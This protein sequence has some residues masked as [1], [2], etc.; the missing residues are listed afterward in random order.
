MT[1]R[2]RLFIIANTT[3]YLNIKTY[4]KTHSPADNFVVLT[5]RRFKGYSDFYDRIKH[6]PDFE[7]LKIIFVDQKKK[8]P[9]HYLDIFSIMGNI[10]GVKQKHPEFDEVLFSN[11]N[12]WV[13]HYLLNQYKLIKPILISDGTGIFTIADLRKTSIA[14]PFA[15]SKFFI[16]KVLGLK[17]LESLH[18]YSQVPVNVPDHDSVEIFG[19]SASNSTT[20]DEEKVYFVGSPLVELGY[21][22]KQ[23]HIDFL[24]R[25]KNQFENSNFIYFSHRRE[26]EEN[27]ED[28]KF[29]GKI[30]RDS[31]PFE[32]RM[33]KEE[34]LPGIVIS[35]ISSILIN[36]PQV[37]PQVKFYYRSLDKNDL[38]IN[39]NF[40]ERYIELT[41]NFK[42]MEG[43]NFKELK[44]Q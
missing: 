22:E 4:I 18:F 32:E 3:H 28:Y 11:Y 14:I 17:P 43:D 21:L 25:I 37:Y 13:Q 19:F 35:Y 7:L 20:V 36:L 30:T 31:I 33:E 34:E 9:F 24:H 39:M 2:K 5:I 42:K 38:N 10:K 12:S 8:F 15:G 6:D 29:L 44:V 23:N 41:E 26:K 16:N 27:L 40:K 1:R